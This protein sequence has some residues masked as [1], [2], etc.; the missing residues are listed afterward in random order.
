MINSRA[1][2]KRKKQYH[3]ILQ[4]RCSVLY[5]SIEYSILTLRVRVSVQDYQLRENW[6]QER[7]YTG[8]ELYILPSLVNRKGKQ[9]DASIFHECRATQVPLP[10]TTCIREYSSQARG[11]R[12]TKS[13]GE[14]FRFSRS[15]TMDSLF[16]LNAS[17]MFITTQFCNPKIYYNDGNPNTVNLIL[18]F[19]DSLL[20][21]RGHFRT[22]YKYRHVLLMWSFCDVE[23]ATPYQ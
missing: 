14:K 2:Q 4:L 9:D 8:I 18:Y 15:G 1:R 23:R 10:S 16:K 22:L 21:T 5:K 6:F 3:K 11:S 19:K 17:K 13:I 7:D 20:L 12:Q